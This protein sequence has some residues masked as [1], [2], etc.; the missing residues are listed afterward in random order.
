MSNTT[1]IA[2]K[3][4]HFVL[5]IFTNKVNFFIMWAVSKCI[6]FCVYILYLI[7]ICSALVNLACGNGQPIYLGL[8][9]RRTAAG[10]VYNYL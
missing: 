9:E 3:V 1:S 10:G 6:L 5:Q 8:Q 2:G 4:K 7:K